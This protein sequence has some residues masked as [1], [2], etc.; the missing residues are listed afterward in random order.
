MQ[1]F[2][3]LRRAGRT[4]GGSAQRV[5]DFADKRRIAGCRAAVGRPRRFP[6]GGGTQ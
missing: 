4:S 2:F 3:K 6:G 1:E 5:R